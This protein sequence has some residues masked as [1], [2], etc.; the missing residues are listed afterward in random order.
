MYEKNEK[1]NISVRDILQTLS[2][3]CL[4]FLKGTVYQMEPELREQ[5]EHRS[6]LQPHN[7]PSRELQSPNRLFRDLKLP[8]HPFL[9]PKSPIRHFLDHSLPNSP[10]PESRFPNSPFPGLNRLS[11]GPNIPGR[12]PKELSILTCIRILDILDINPV[13]SSSQLYSH[14]E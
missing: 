8:N 5:E 11:P 3:T 12:V 9:G 4:P 10:F 7:Y 13:I 1:K 6:S 2:P 14:L